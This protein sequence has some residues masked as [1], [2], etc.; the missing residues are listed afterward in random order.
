LNNGSVV[1]GLEAGDPTHI[2]SD[3]AEPEV[4]DVELTSLADVRN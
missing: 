3:N 1:R 4:V 2:E